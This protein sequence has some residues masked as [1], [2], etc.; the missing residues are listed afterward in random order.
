MRAQVRSWIDHRIMRNR[1][2]SVGC[3]CLMK[4][5]TLVHSS[6]GLRPSEASIAGLTFTSS[7]RAFH[8]H[9]A[10]PAPSTASARSCSSLGAAPNNGSS[11][12]KA[13]WVTVKPM[14]MRM[15]TRPATR[16][17][18]AAS[19][20]RRPVST[21]EAPN[22]QM[23]NSIHVGISDSARSWPRRARN[24]ANAPP[25]AP[26]M[27]NEV[28]AKVEARRG[29]ITATATSVSW[30]MIHTV[31]SMRMRPCQ[32]AMRRNTDMKMT[33]LAATADSLAAR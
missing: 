23:R 5:S 9:T 16:P 30:A 4:S 7:R 2:R 3:R 26:M 18:T 32:N 8:S 22:T 14:R 25:T 29:S 1:S 10:E 19:P 11:E 6:P 13:N 24:R 28:R 31:N 21:I 33:R 12:R 15:S 20:D 27:M 17:S